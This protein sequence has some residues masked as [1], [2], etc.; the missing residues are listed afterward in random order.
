[1]AKAG[2]KERTTTDVIH[3]VRVEETTK[4]EEQL[5]RHTAHLCIHGWRDVLWITGALGAGIVL[6]LAGERRLTGRWRALPVAVGLVVS[7]AARR[8][9][10]RHT[11]FAQKAAMVVG[12]FALITSTIHFTLQ[13]RIDADRALEA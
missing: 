11:R 7:I 6:G 9:D 4:R 2:Q 12:G 3:E 5:A 10:P 1:M 8:T 13:T